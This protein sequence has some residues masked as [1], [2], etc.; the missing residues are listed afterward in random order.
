MELPMATLTEEPK[1]GE[2]KRKSNEV[3]GFQ[4]KYWKTVLVSIG[5]FIGFILLLPIMPIITTY[6]TTKKSYFK[7]YFKTAFFYI[8]MFPKYLIHGTLTRIIRYNF[9]MTPTQVEE[10]L[11]A[12][13]GACTR[14][15]KCCNQVGCLFLGTDENE[16]TICTA[17]GTVFWYYGGCGRYPLSQK[18]IDDHACPGF[19]FIDEEN[20]LVYEV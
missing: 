12:R 3:A 7:N 20:K 19:S 5:A 2:K 18:D 11:A 8:R 9:F 16:N 14:C 4:Y 17:Y 13:K 10:R 1:Q 15:G 6:Q